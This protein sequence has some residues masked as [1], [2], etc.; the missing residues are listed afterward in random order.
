VDPRIASALSWCTKRGIRRLLLAAP[1]ALDPTTLELARSRPEVEGLVCWPDH[2]ESPNNDND[3]VFLP[4][5]YSWRLPDHC[6]PHILFIDGPGA[7]TARMI[8]TALRRRVRTVGFTTLGTWRRRA[9]PQLA[10]SKLASK[11]AAKCVEKGR[12]PCQI[13]VD[14]WYQRALAPVL[15][16]APFRFDTDSTQTP[17]KGIVIACPTLVAG[18]AE[19]QIVNTAIGLK[20]A[21]LGPLTVL[22]SRLH[23]PPGNAFFLERLIAAGVQVREVASPSSSL[24]RWSRVRALAANAEGRR[25]LTLLQHLPQALAQEILDLGIELAKL[26][27]SV[28]HSWLD[29]SNTRAGLAAAC[30]GVP[31][32]ILSGRNVSPR[33]FSYIH[34]PFMRG[35]YRAL[36]ARPAVVLCNNSHG[37]AADYADWLG[38]E[39]AEIEVVYNGVDLTALR[40]PS[41]GER[42]AFRDNLDIDAS[43][44]LVG[45]MFR[46]SA[47]KRP[48]LWLDIA[49]LIARQLPTARFLLFGEGPLRPD[50]E[51]KIEASGLAAH[52][53]L[54]PPT[55]DIALVLGAFDLL[56]LTS[57]WEGTPNVAIEA[58]A[59]GTPVILTGGGGA[60]E[61]IADG[62]T[63]IYV[64][65]PDPDAMARAAIGALPPQSRMRLGAVRDFVNARFGMEQMVE[66]TRKLYRL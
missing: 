33:H 7:L 43:A 34:E 8:T 1:F 52:L 40:R 41:D 13:L 11:L 19:R 57:Q 63:G 12:G 3:G 37:G 61:A 27:P 23:N 46:F 36:L 44:P 14:Q 2:P 59:V 53:R 9:L 64:E 17:R 15:A 4:E 10:F 51:H 30:A 45:G 20:T 65:Q 16:A 24:Q 25:T 55:A 47:E 38:I 48:L 18:G 32:I 62:T 66:R 56:L 31:R 39:P 50:M 26:N 35:A 54:L 60:K 5:V 49:A 58:Q 28:V 29:Y 22:V 21:G 42:A 6:P